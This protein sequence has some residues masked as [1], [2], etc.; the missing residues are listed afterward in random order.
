M[1]YCIIR[2]LEDLLEALRRQL[3]KRFGWPFAFVHFLATRPKKCLLLRC[4]LMRH[5]ILNPGAAFP[6]DGKTAD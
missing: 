5:R 4:L 1:R 6:R 3:V 2:L